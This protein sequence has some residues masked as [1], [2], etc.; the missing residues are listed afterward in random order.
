[1]TP[2]GEDPYGDFL[3]A[4]DVPTWRRCMDA[5]AALTFE[6]GDGDEGNDRLVQALTITAYVVWLGATSGDLESEKVGRRRHDE[7]R[8]ELDRRYRGAASPQLRRCRGIEF[9]WT[10]YHTQACEWLE[11]GGRLSTEHLLL[12]LPASDVRQVKALRPLFRGDKVCRFLPA[13]HIYGTALVGVGAVHEAHD[14]VTSGDWDSTDPMLLDILGTTNERLGQ[15]SEALAA[16]RM[17]SWPIHRYR[18]AMIGAISKADMQASDALVLDE[19]TRRFIAN[20]GDELDQAEMTRCIG[21]LNACMWNPVDDWV[22]ERELA[23]LS[24][25]RRRFAEAEFHLSRS[26]KSAPERATFPLAHLR[27]INLTW[28]ASQ[29]LGSGEDVGALLDMTPEA[30]QAGYDAISCA[31][32]TDDTTDIRTWI[33]RDDLTLIPCSLEDWTPYD[34]SQAYETVG[35]MSRSIDA[36]MESLDTAYGHRTVNRLM[37]VLG[38]AGFQ[39]TTAHLAELVLR[40]SHEDF[41]ALWETATTV[42]ALVPHDQDDTERE[43]MLI[44]RFASRLRELSEL[45]FKNTVRSYG[46]FRSVGL[47]DLAE[48]MLVAATRLAEGVSELLSVAVL[49]RKAG[50]ARTGRVDLEGRRCLTEAMAEARDRI[51]RLEIARELFY[52]GRIRDGRS[53][54]E[55]EGVLAGD[56]SLSPIEYTAALQCA[57]WLTSEERADLAHG[58]AAQ[59][60]F[61]YRS[62]A[63]GNRPASFGQRLI[64]TIATADQGLA[65]RIQDELA[66][67]LAEEPPRSDWSG[68]TDNAWPAVSKRIDGL[69][70]EDDYA[71]LAGIVEESSRSTSFGLRLVLVNRLRRTFDRLIDNAQAVRPSVPPEETPISKDPRFDGSRTIELCDLWRARLSGTG[72]PEEAAAALNGFFAA[73]AEIETQWEDRR[74]LAGA[75]IWQGIAHVLDL[76]GVAL[77]RLLTPEDP[78]HVNPIIAG[79]FRAAATDV[80]T[81][82]EELADHR[83]HAELEL[84]PVAIA[85]R[86]GNPP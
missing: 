64:A 3:A 16:Y 38:P 18:A 65:R 15:W 7:L 86:A 51:E 79:I 50:G 33:A 47:S 19:P 23:N 4:A 32:P 48:E 67:P 36:S 54:L 39:A 84:A 74:R 66:A 29:S 9:A 42:A 72:R 27:F 6:L 41:F 61:E 69:L 8:A 53:I 28:L 49:R 52:Y 10:G 56:R 60:N 75:E 73:E 45:E 46:F 26:L 70:A 1:M 21:F 34:R 44:E 81:L 83:H 25:R 82:L 85:D 59:L 78:E 57:P 30:I 68:A 62:G 14:L 12:V 63:L 17:S 77:Q 58:A 24:F 22:I 31:D 55:S 2:R 35:D 80:D 5:T 40:E 76:L 20:F 71:A 13:V 11:Q 37:S 43:P